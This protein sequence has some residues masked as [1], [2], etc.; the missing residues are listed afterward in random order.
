MKDIINSFKA[1][2]YERTSSP[3]IGAFIFYWLIFNYKMVVVL[4]DDKLKS[5]EKFTNIDTIY[6]NDLF[7]NIPLNGVIYPI[8]ATLLY[9]LVFPWIS[10]LIFEGW[11]YHQNN[12]KS[13][14]NKKVLTYKEYGDLQRR[15]TELELSFDDTFSKKDNEITSLKSLLSKKESL[16]LEQKK[17]IESNKDKEILL[18]QTLIEKEKYLKEINELKLKITPDIKPSQKKHDNE[19]EKLINQILID[20]SNTNNYNILDLKDDYKLHKI[21]AEQ[22]INKLF[23]LEYVQQLPHYA[24]GY[25]SITKKAEQYL[26]D[27]HLI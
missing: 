14:G 24:D 6:Q 17:L 23:E 25:I 21:R 7:F 4:F 15:F 12:L 16:I 1:H 19:D 22:I 8:I 9:L 18:Q 10:N 5:S 20:V 3:L 11:T 26:L 2:L 27:N 13:I